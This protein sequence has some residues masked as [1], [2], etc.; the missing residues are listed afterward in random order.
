MAREVREERA[1]WF[2]LSRVPG[3]IPRKLWHLVNS[4]GSARAVW[5]ASPE[6]LIQSGL[7]PRVAQRIVAC[8]STGLS[9]VVRSEKQGVHIV[10]WADPQYPSLLRRIP[11]P[12]PVLYVRGR[13]IPEDEVA[14]AIVGARKASTYGKMVAE[15]LAF[16]LA[17]CGVTVVSGLARGIDGA[18][19]RGALRGG[20]RTIGVLG[21]GVD[22]VYPPEHRAL[23]AE[24]TEGGAV[25]S[26]L[27]CGTPPLSHH[28]PMRNR[29]ISGLS[30]GV[31]VVEGEE[32][33][34]A[35]ITADCALEQG[36]EVLAVP[37]SILGGKS[38]A[39]H[40][41]LKQGAKPVERVEDILEELRLP[42]SRAGKVEP[43]QMEPLEAEVFSC[44]THEPRHIDAIVQESGL[45][46]HRVAGVLLDLEVKGVVCQ[47]P[48]KRF[49]RSLGSPGL[50]KAKGR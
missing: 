19:H 16:E 25:L 48:G 1:I 10:T 33:S 46:P 14:V 40:Q 12:P 17:R 26:E 6:T 30:L 20:G 23:I 44:L 2:A 34:G 4:L 39:P 43:L 28:F 29:I 37:G 50:E 3:L 31:V 9:A 36:R 27:P 32:H 7:S 42:I 5:E 18:A 38:H 22:V 13:L 45:E 35:L 47:L 21:C 49:A 11:D 15:G 41:L 24:V 8:R